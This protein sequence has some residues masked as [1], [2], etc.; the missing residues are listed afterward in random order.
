[1]GGEEF[2]LVLD[3]E[4]QEEEELQGFFVKAEGE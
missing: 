2:E 4:L 1:V 3:S